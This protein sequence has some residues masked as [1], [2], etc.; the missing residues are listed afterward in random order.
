[1][2]E[3]RGGRM[4]ITVSGLDGAGKSTLIRWLR[5][6]LERDGHRVTVLH[7]NTHVGLYAYARYVR[8]RLVGVREKPWETDARATE[9][10]PP[11]LIQRV[12][13]ALVW[14]KVVRELVYVIDLVLFLGYRFYVETLRRQVLIMDRYFYDSLV[15]VANGKNWHVLRLLERLTPTPDIA[16]L[17]DVAPEQAYARKREQPFSYLERR[18]RAYQVVFP[19]IPTAEVIANQNIRTAESRLYGTVQRCLA[20][21]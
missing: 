12:R 19:W 16:F 2:G 17:L 4:L 15:D 9:T 11:R 10:R 8:D 20:R 6:T 13:T 18:W 3:R 7:L 5:G 21:A 1:M 14:S